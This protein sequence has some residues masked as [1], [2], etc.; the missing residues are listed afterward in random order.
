[1]IQSIVD[2]SWIAYSESH[3][4]VRLHDGVPA[5]KEEKLFPACFI[6]ML[7]TISCSRSLHLGNVVQVNILLSKM[8]E[9]KKSSGSTLVEDNKESK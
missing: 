8:L 6:K 5:G 3:E 4:N 7:V 2:F 1:M 9:F